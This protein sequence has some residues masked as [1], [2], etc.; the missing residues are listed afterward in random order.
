MREQVQVDAQYL[1]KPKHVCHLVDMQ[2]GES[3]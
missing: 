1:D 2:L 3:P